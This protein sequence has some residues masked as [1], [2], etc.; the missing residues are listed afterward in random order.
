MK[1]NALG[2]EVGRALVAKFLFCYLVC[3]AEEI[4]FDFSIEGVVKFHVYFT[5]AMCCKFITEF[6]NTF[7]KFLFGD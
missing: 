3:T 4:F 1:C 6:F 2:C 5:F 7:L